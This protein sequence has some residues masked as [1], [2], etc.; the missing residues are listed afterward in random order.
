MRDILDGPVKTKKNGGC[1]VAEKFKNRDP[2]KSM[3]IRAGH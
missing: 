1:F 2:Y 3:S